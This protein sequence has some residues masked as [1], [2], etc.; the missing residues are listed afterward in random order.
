MILYKKGSS[1]AYDEAWFLKHC[2]KRVLTAGKSSVGSASSTWARNSSFKAESSSAS[3]VVMIFL[4]RIF[5]GESLRIL[6][7]F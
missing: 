3:S 1:S 2:V 7:G 4:I 5:H 6:I